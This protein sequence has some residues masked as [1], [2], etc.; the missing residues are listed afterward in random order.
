MRIESKNYEIWNDL[1]WY[2]PRWNF[3]VFELLFTYNHLSLAS[4]SVLFKHKLLICVCFCITFQS[5]DWNIFILPELQRPPLKMHILWYKAGIYNWDLSEKVSL[6]YKD[7][8][9]IPPFSNLKY[10]GFYFIHNSMK[11]SWR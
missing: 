10:I 7:S 8:F 6:M 11:D 9:P 5:F 1:K 3:K 2:L 4:L